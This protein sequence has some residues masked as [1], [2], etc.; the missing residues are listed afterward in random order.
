MLVVGSQVDGVICVVH[1]DHTGAEMVAD[2]VRR[3][4]EKG[5]VVVG[6]VLNQVSDELLRRHQYNYSG[7]YGRYNYYGSRDSDT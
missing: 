3:L 6:A 5:S 7:Y 2:S 4:R 1:A